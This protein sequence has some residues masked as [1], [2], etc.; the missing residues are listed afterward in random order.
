MML[1]GHVNG[2]LPK[3]K[4]PGKEGIQNLGVY[5]RERS[6]CVSSENVSIFV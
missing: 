5:D 2:A 4:V 3:E 1:Q 6:L